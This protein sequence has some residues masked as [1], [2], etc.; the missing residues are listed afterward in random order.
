[1]KNVPT[2]PSAT[3]TIIKAGLLAGTL[4]IL[5]AIVYY[6]FKTGKNGFT[7]LN[8]VASGAFGKKAITGGTRMAAAGLLFH[9]FIAFCWTIVF[10]FI[11]PYLHSVIKNKIVAGLVYGILIWTIMNLVIVPMSAIPKRP[12]ILSAAII[13]MVILMLAV[14]LPLSLITDNY[15]S[16][17]TKINHGI[18]QS[19]TV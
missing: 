9:Y 5:S 1:M 10:F 14:G 18:Q 16:R 2:K 3:G 19:Q 6:Y 11:Y 12:F 17:L 7:V 8:F 4:D 13:N 15:Y